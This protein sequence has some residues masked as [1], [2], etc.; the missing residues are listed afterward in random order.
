MQGSD[1]AELKYT[2]TEVYFNGYTITANLSSGALNVCGYEDVSN[3]TTLWKISNPFLDATPFVTNLC[4]AILL[5]QL[6]FLLFHRLPRFFS[7]L[8]V[9]ILYTN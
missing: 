1:K 7:E 5:I 9:S 6:L 8:I 3:S 2:A 4:S